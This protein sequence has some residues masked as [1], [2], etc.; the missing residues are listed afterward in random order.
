M[1]TPAPTPTSGLR[2]A[3]LQPFP[4]G[5]SLSIPALLQ[6]D[7]P[8]LLSL[9]SPGS[10]LS[11]WVLGTWSKGER[12]TFLPRVTSQHCCGSLAL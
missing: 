5:T 10:S 4:L 12:L 3:G 8:A 11:G 1:H 9:P 7:S 6:P 2:L